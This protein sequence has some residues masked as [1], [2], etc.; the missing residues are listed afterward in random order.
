MLIASIGMLDAAVA[1]WPLDGMGAPSPVPGLLVNELVMLAF[2]A[3]LV[4]WDLHTR[5]RLHS[6]TVARTPA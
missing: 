5:R 2:L 4:V 3:P 1:R 6:V